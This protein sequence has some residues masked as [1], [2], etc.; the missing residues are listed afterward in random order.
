M[1]PLTVR[2]RYIAAIILLLAVCRTASS[3]IL[4]EDFRNIGCTNCREGDD[5]YEAFLAQHPEYD[6]TLVY[7][8]NN[9]PT[10]S[11]PFYRAAK[12]SVDMRVDQYGVFGDP[13]L[14]IQGTFVVAD[15]GTFFSKAKQFTQDLASA[16]TSNQP[17]AHLAMSTST[18]ADGTFSIKVDVTGSQVSPAGVKLYVMVLESDIVY[19]NAA[20][21]GR[22]DGDKWHN[23][24][25]KTLPDPDGTEVFT[26]NNNSFSFTLDTTGTHWNSKNIKLVAF[27]QES[28]KIGSN[29][30]PI[31]AIT[32]A[33]LET[34]GVSTSMVSS[35]IVGTPSQNPFSVS[36]SV[37]LEL[38]KPSY[39]KA[40]V[41]NS[42]GQQV[43]VIADGMI[44]GPKATLSFRPYS[45]SAGMYYLTVTIDGNA[46]VTRQI[47][48]QP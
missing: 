44:S 40:V 28:K 25:R 29:S 31:Y 48:Y 27:I 4:A 15:G 9:A 2:F 13:T 35:T 37:P 11:D 46:P 36:T 5:Q 22:T 19:I 26:V 21:Y 34:S 10:A 43:A 6:V 47:A 14:F 7:L 23:M 16:L 42:L 38:S 39:V 24:L 32:K 1:Q 30:F 17:T 18:N 12:S 3:Q 8:H 20:A 41:S 45:L 33:S